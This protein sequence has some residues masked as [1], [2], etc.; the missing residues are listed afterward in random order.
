MQLSSKTEL[1]EKSSVKLI[2]TV[3]EEEIKKAYD[4]IISNYCKNLQ[5][6]GFR[7]G[8]IPKDVLVRKFGEALKEETAQKVMEESLKETL[9]T[10]EHYPLPYSQ[11]TVANENFNFEIDK[12]FTY[13]ILYDTYPKV[14]LGT[15]MGLEVEEPVIEIADADM[16]SE[17]KQLQEQN[18]I[19]AE[20]KDPVIEDG[21]IVTI[22]YI[23]LDDDDNEKEDTKRESF[24]FTVGTGYNLYD[25]DNDI[26]GLKKDEEKVIEKEYADDYKYPSLAGKTVKVKVKITTVKE[27]VLPEL[28]DEL[29][30]DISDKYQ[31]LEDLK[32]DIRNKL[33]LMAEEKVRENKI[34]QLI[35][36]IVKTSQI[37][38]PESMV[39]QELEIKWRTLLYQFRNNE[40]LLL[41][42]LKSENKT[43]DD[44]L[45]GLRPAAEESIK[46]S[47]VVEEIAK[48]ENIFVTEEEMDEEIKKIAE[49]QKMTLEE[50]K[51]TINT[52]KMSESINLNIRNQKLFTYLLKHS[53]IKE[54]KNFKFA[55][56]IRGNEVKE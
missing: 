35:E 32:T 2:I 38:L 55:D 52:N 39:K 7:K 36:K 23:E 21:N 56:F 17:L 40:K 11:P 13:E 28:D 22:D 29:A 18:S 51:R 3:P 44:F 50:A 31:T 34:T 12:D 25:F 48:K 47:I 37:D 8:K 1:L 33:K 30:Q 41:N 5:I 15:Y 43:K 42:Q 4:E 46:S 49:A 26:I 16:D 14:E 24:T 10:V 9:E 45:T 20:K 27:K 19:I 54:G 53:N 6:K